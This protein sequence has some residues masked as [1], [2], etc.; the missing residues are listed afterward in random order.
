MPYKQTATKRLRS[1]NY[2]IKRSN[3]AHQIYST[4]IISD[5]GEPKTVWEAMKGK[6]KQ[7][8]IPY[9]GNM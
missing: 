9:L 2:S 6:E 8:W 4:A 5:P 1:L 7:K 3:I